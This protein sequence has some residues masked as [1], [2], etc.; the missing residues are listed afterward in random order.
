MPQLFE[1]VAELVAEREQSEQPETPTEALEPDNAL[2]DT[3]EFIGALRAI[4]C[5]ELGYDDWLRVTM[6]AKVAGVP[7]SAW[8]EWNKTDLRRY[9][10]KANRRTWESI[11]VEKRGGITDLT[12][13]QYARK[14][15]WKG[16]EQPSPSDALGCEER[17]V[18]RKL[19]KGKPTGKLLHNRVG[20]ALIE[21]HHAVMI[22]GMTPAIWSCG[23]YVPGWSGI[24]VEIINLVRDATIFEQREV[25]HYL[26]RK[27]PK[28]SAAPPNLIAFSN[29]VL[30]VLTGEMLPA[31]PDI[32]ITNVI[33]HEYHEEVYDETA[34]R[35]L[36]DIACGDSATRK[37]L[38]E[39]IGLCMYR[40]SEFGVCPVLTGTGS[41]GKSTYL[42][43][44][45]TVLG[46]ENIAALGM[47]VLGQ[48]F[49]GTQIVGKL[50][51]LGD[52]ISNV[53][54]SG[55][56]LATFK[57]IVTGD[58]VFTD[59]KMGEGYSF[60]PYVTLVFACN[61]IPSLEDHSEGTLR[62]LAPIP[63]RATFTPEN[64]GYDR[65]IGRKITTEGASQYLIRVGVQGLRRMMESNGLTPNPNSRDMLSEVRYDNDPVLQYVEE[66]SIQLACLVGKTVPD[67]RAGYEAWAERTG[68]KSISD[69]TFT[70]RLRRCFPDLETYPSGGVRRY[71]IR[72]S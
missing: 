8:D 26:S 35:F 62:R 18:F 36:S 33:P 68:H 5:A 21:E 55:D 4:P 7:Y 51:N 54:L 16:I 41:N 39:V 52:D 59:V 71:R 2:I 15:G 30:D 66:N 29:G 64:A 19:V 40:S 69:N 63:F 31:S 67:C 46:D 49:M 23:R 3:A 47:S 48:R 50:A 22:D 20:D 58:R 45:A 6:G 72:N 32:V 57:V 27:A 61:E 1:R 42:K 11:E 9:D 12:L 25:C 34:D 10:C 70:K 37:N 53:R 56:T 13:Y 17:S 60:T 28:V 14:H 44:V 38:E 43:A 24:E 65:L